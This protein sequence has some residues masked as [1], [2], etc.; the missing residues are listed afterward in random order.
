MIINLKGTFRN[1]VSDELKKFLCSFKD[2]EIRY[3]QISKFKFS[4]SN[5]SHY[6]KHLTEIN[7]W[8]VVFVKV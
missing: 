8:Y 1:K 2:K 5:R 7:F 4:F 3:L 6:F